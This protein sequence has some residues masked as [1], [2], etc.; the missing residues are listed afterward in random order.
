MD[1]ETEQK[2][3]VYV[4]YRED[5]GRPFYVGK[6]VDCRVRKSKRNP[7]HTKIK[8]KHGMVRKVLF[9]TI[10]QQEAFDKEVEL[11]QELKTHVD[12]GEGGANFTL[13]GDGTT[14]YKWNEEQREACKKKWEN[15]E[16]KQRMSE[17]QKKSWENQDK[18]ERMKATKRKKWED[19]E[20]KEKMSE[21]FKKTWSDPELRK[22]LS[23]Q[24]QKVWED[25]ELLKKHSEAIKDSLKKPEIKEKHR[26]SIR[27]AWEKRKAKK[28][29]LNIDSNS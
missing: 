23:E 10:N 7:L 14:G 25:P 1:M 27:K 8:N 13:G 9:E 11:I 21:S 29:N 4:D 6:G 20:F 17:L 22:K 18:K 19:P 5:D 15:P 16:F 26:E 28:A 24:Q 12:F 3:F 2:F